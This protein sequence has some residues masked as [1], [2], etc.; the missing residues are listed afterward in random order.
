MVGAVLGRYPSGC[1]LR[2]PGDHGTGGIDRIL[3]SAGSFSVL[4]PA[5]EPPPP[6]LLLNGEDL[7]GEASAMVVIVVVCENC[8]PPPVA[9]PRSCLPPPVDAP[10]APPPPRAE[11]GKGAVEASIRE[12]FRLGLRDAG[13]DILTVA[14]LEA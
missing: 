2:P 1:G 5:G 13:G 10:A 9:F 12:L 3:L 14:L 4:P 8:F 6:R 11:D 7:D